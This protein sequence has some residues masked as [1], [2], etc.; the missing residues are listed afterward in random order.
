[1]PFQLLPLGS[2][3]FR[4]ALHDLRDQLVTLL[5]GFSGVIDEAALNGSP[6]STVVF[7]KVHRKEWREA[8]VAILFPFV[9]ILF[10]FQFLVRG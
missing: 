2:E 6:A 8:F 1:L 7:G 9:P 4:Q 3:R 5:D 10:V